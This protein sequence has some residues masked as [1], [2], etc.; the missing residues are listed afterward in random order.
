ME[1]VFKNGSEAIYPLHRSGVGE[2]R[3]LCGNEE[4]PELGHE[5]ARVALQEAR[6]VDLLAAYS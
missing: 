3:N 4:L 5:G 1:I 6:Q 2:G